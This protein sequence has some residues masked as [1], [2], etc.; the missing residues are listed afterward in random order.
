MTGHEEIRALEVV[1]EVKLVALDAFKGKIVNV[2][3]RVQIFA[4]FQLDDGRRIDRLPL[5]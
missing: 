5:R 4:D 3:S 1:T 2:P